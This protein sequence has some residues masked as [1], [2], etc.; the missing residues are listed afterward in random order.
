MATPRVVR[1]PST[2]G[3]Y[4]PSSTPI[5]REARYLLAE[6]PDLRDTAL[7]LSVLGAVADGH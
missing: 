7:Y 6:E 2:T 5:F 4:E 1:R 3:S